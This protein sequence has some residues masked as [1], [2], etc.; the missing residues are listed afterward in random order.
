MNS[1]KNPDTVAKRRNTFLE[2]HNYI[3]YIK[4]IMNIDVSMYDVYYTK[5]CRQVCKEWLD[6]HHP[7]RGPQS[8]ITGIGTLLKHKD[9]GHTFIVAM[10]TFKKSR[11]KAYWVELSRM[12]SL[13]DENE[14]LVH[15]DKMSEIAS[16]LGLYNIVAYINTSFDNIYAYKSIGMKVVKEMPSLRW[17][18]TDNGYFSQSQICNSRSQSYLNLNKHITEPLW[19]SGRYEMAF[20]EG[21]R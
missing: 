2:R 14:S 20:S 16:Q 12:W 11:N 4:P 6:A 21:S 15:Y 3:Q 17:Y 13:L 8:I 19:D 1:M 10:M 7:L 9:T 5:L 18:C